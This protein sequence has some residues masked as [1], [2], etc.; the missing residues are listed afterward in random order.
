LCCGGKDDVGD[1]S[2]DELSREVDGV[3]GEVYGVPTLEGE[4]S[5]LL[6]ALWLSELLLDVVED[7]LLG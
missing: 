2:T 6:R 5:E 4:V 3:P 1:D 7:R